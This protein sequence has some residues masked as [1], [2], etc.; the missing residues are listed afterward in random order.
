MRDE[1]TGLHKEQQPAEGLQTPQGHKGQLPG[2]QPLHTEGG[3]SGESQG[4]LSEGLRWD[5]VRQRHC[6]PGPSRQG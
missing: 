5:A 4:S 1:A 2:V 6:T 3:A